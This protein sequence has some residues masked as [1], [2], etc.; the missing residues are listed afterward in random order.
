MNSGKHFLEPP[1]DLARKDGKRDSLRPDT[2]L[3]VT[4]PILTQQAFDSNYG[5]LE[6]GP[7]LRPWGEIKRIGGKLWKRKTTSNKSCPKLAYSFITS[8]FPVIA[9]L[10]KY[11]FKRLLI[12]D[13]VA[14]ITVGVMNVPQG[15]AYAILAGLPPV[16]GLYTSF[17]PTLFYFAMGTSRQC[18]MGTFAI[19]SMMTNKIVG[20]YSNPVSMSMATT[21]G[22]TVAPL[23]S[24]G[25]SG[26]VE[27]STT[28]LLP[29]EKF[30]EREIEAIRVAT[31][32]AFVVGSWQLLLG[33]LK[34]GGLTVYLSD[35]LVQGFTCA[36]AFHV[37]SSQLTSVFGVK[38]LHEFFG[39]FK[40]VKTYIRFFE[41]IHTAHPPAMIISAVT[42]VIL[43]II[44]YGINKNKKIRAIIRVPVPAELIIVII[45]ASVSYSFEFAENYDVVTVANVPTGMPPPTVPDFRVVVDNPA[46]LGDTFALA[47]VAFAITV[48]LGMLF[49]NEHNYAISPN[50]EFKALGVGNIVGS[51]FQSMPSGA[52][53]ARSAVQNGAGGRTQIVSLVQSTIVL[54]VILAL[55]PLL[56]P[57]PRACLGGI[58]MVA[59]IHLLEQAVELVHLWKISFVDWTI[60]LVVF[61]SV[62]ILDVDIGVGIGVAYA[63]M[64]VM[65]RMQKPKVRGLGRLPGTDLYKP[66]DIYTTAYQRPEVRIVRIDAPIY[67]A[68]AAYIK[69][70]L[71]NLAGLHD[72]MRELKEE[73]E[74]T[75]NDEKQRYAF[76]NTIVIEDNEEQPPVEQYER[77][78]SRVS[79]GSKKSHAHLPRTVTGSLSQEVLKDNEIVSDNTDSTD[80]SEDASIPKLHVVIDCSEVCFV[81]VTGV[82]FLKKTADECRNIGV[83]LLL[84]CTKKSVRDMLEICEA[85][86]LNAPDRLFVTVHDAV[87]YALNNQT[88][89]PLA[90]DESGKT[91]NENRQSDTRM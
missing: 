41:V 90:V 89:Q 50:Q 70:R 46:I 25:N 67:F 47:V 6:P 48:T 62:L 1:K 20:S 43:I 32:A 79:S 34:F 30:N 7:P 4:R 23:L 64:T 57:L 53:L 86:E 68:N 60:F 45:G 11:D 8:W 39:P 74:D 38:G 18:S 88:V 44:K 14:G 80:G 27:N 16:C 9:W 71:Y 75:E 19:I 82:G 73:K 12:P 26:I 42:I 91:V 21:L 63:I 59:V 49:A 87:L 56:Q 22:T 10:P 29:V 61:L 17:I 31:T 13:F 69:T 83:T 3:R 51:F 81:D 24:T 37:F 36:S 40:L 35:Q 76:T 66:M 84:A 85:S 72:A 5:L 28:P 52:S 77:K 54:V 78:L 33:I 15:I 65:F 2:Q 55:G 58:V